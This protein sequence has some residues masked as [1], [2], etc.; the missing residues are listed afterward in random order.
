MSVFSLFSKAVTQMSDT[1]AKR[2]QAI[3]AKQEELQ[4]ARD[5]LYPLPD[6]EA[7]IADYVQRTRTHWLAEHGDSLLHAF[8]AP[9]EVPGLVVARVSAL[10]ELFNHA[11]VVK[12]P[13]E[14][15]EQIILL[16]RE[17]ARERAH[18]FGPPLADRPALSAQLE[19]ELA[20]LEAA[21]EADVDQA[22]ED[23]RKANVQITI[24]HRPEVLARREEQR[25]RDQRQR[26]AERAELARLAA[27]AREPRA[28]AIHM[29]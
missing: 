27:A 26:E 13:D 4:R 11:D 25:I 8:G 22:I 2:R 1:L 16:A 7:R 28:T 9:H 20:T 10:S 24:R 12:K 21:E 23:A 15:T 19:Q 3:A 17:R 6:I 5:A 14:T 29:P 18:T